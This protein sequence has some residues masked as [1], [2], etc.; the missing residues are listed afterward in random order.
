MAHSTTL[1]TWLEDTTERRKALPE[2]ATARF[3]PMLLAGIVLV[4]ATGL[5]WR[6][7]QPE[8][9]GQFWH[10]YL[11][12]VVFFSSISLGGLFLVVV[13]HLTGAHWG[14]VVR[15]LAEFIAMAIGVCA[16]MWI[17]IW[18]S[19]L[20]DDSSLY[21][22][23]KPGITEFK[24][25]NYDELIAGKSPYLNKAFF[26]GR[27]VFFFLLWFAIARYYFRS[28]IAQDRAHDNR[29]MRWVRSL[30]G[31]SMLVFALS[32]TFASFD[33]MMTLAPHW[34]STIFGVYYFAGCAVAIFAVLAVAVY[35]LQARGI[36][37]RSI[38]VEHYHDL[39]KLLFGF[40]VF[41]A[42]IA[43]SQFML[44]W[45]ADLPEE[46]SWF[47]QRQSGL[48]EV[49]IPLPV[50]LLFVIHFFIPFLG[51]LSRHVRRHKGAMAFWGVYML[52]AHWIDLYFV[53]GM[54]QA[55][56]EDGPFGWIW[57]IGPTELLVTLGLGL[58]YVGTI[59]WFAA[60]R[61]LIP[62]RD[63][64]LALSLDFKNH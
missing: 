16:L 29:P 12:G 23:N 7:K 45:Y 57:P 64:R 8:A 61:W 62:V 30:S 9:M 63:P 21:E 49:G 50:T 48:S 34:F 17:P 4:V 44:I 1:D 2:L 39:G 54:Q 10:A 31:V 5:W 60:G 15:R 41:W 18:L 24:H 36:L 28:S 51:L 25:A 47:E 22:W 52:V 20:A 32:L 46:T 38:T 53:V 59:Y 27:S 42:Y 11:L 40:V 33:W 26:I 37:T 58:V 55:K 56:R 13:Q 3:V 35:L 6:Y 43:F 19:L 14:V